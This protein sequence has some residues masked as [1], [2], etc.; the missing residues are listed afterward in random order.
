MRD[1]LFSNSLNL[2]F[3]F[4]VVVPVSTKIIMLIIEV[5]LQNQYQESVRKLTLISHEAKDFG[6]LHFFL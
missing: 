6:V 1:T 3:V 2:V 5:S 4:W